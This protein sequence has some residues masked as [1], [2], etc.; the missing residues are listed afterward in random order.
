MVP[1][2]FLLMLNVRPVVFGPLANGLGEM[3]VT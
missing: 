3:A 2:K 1:M